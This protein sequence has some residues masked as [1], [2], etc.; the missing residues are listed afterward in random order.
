MAYALSLL[1]LGLAITA[2]IPSIAVRKAILRVCGAKLGK[3]VLVYHG[4]EVRSPWKLKIGDGS[5][6]GNGALLDARGKVEIGQNVNLSAEVVILTG[7]HDYQSPDFAYQTGPV[8]IG[9]RAW[10][11]IRCVVLPG[12]SI[13]EGAVVAAGSV[14]NKDVPAYALV[15]G[16]P[17]K[18][19]GSRNTG[20]TYTLGS[21]AGGHLRLL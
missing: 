12:V 11:C 3:G 19:I 17:A 5:V 21:G 1:Q 6:I 7:Q 15:G 16:I 13:G 10:L 14:V 2:Y 8:T 20:L 4:F 18:V 9:D